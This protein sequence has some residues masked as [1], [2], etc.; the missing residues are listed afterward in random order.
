MLNKFAEDLKLKIFD[1]TSVSPCQQELHGWRK[2]PNGTKHTLKSL[3][4][5]KENE[6]FMSPV[7]D[8]GDSSSEM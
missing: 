1:D 4:L 8:I 2:E 7:S 3:E 5:P 6:L